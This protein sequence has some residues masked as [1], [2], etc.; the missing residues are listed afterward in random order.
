MVKAAVYIINRSPTQTMN[1]K[2]P[3]E[4]LQKALDIP[5]PKPVLSHIKV[6]SSRAY[7]K[8]NL[9]L[10]RD[11]VASRIHIGYL[12]GYESTTI[13]RIWIPGKDSIERVRNVT[14][15]E[16]LRYDPDE[17]QIDHELQSQ[18]IETIQIPEL[19]I[20]APKTPD[21][22][23][24]WEDASNRETNQGSS[25]LQDLLESSESTILPQP[26]LSNLSKSQ[27]SIIPTL[28]TPNETPPP[29]LGIGL[30]EDSR[31]TLGPDTDPFSRTAEVQEIGQHQ[32]RERT[33]QLRSTESFSARR[34][35]EISAN[36]DESN[37]L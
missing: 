27:G 35:D 30:T 34:H 37:I 9:I 23:E 17:L 13:Y 11:K 2:T 14:F 25:P 18:L 21:D 6:Y 22:E 15:D 36:F 24:I 16:T 1:W 19:P 26:T 31:E 32:D 3:L 33:S 20:R 12:I 7:V 5:N 4:T 10:K 8:T 29:E 28:P